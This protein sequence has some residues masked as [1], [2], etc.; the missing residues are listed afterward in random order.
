MKLE[1]SIE[2]HAAFIGKFYPISFAEQD[3]AKGVVGNHSRLHVYRAAAYVPIILAYYTFCGDQRAL[4][5]LKAPRSLKLL[6]IGLLFHDVARRGE[7]KDLWEWETESASRYYKYLRELGVNHT[8]AKKYAEAV[9]NKDYKSKKQQ[10]EEQNYYSCLEVSTEENVTWSKTADEVEKSIEAST[11]HECDCLDIK[12]VRRHFDL[13]FLDIIYHERLEGKENFNKRKKLRAIIANIKQLIKMH[14]DD[15]G[16]KDNDVKISYELATNCYQRIIENILSIRLLRV[17]YQFGMLDH[18]MGTLELDFICQ[19]NEYN[20]LLYRFEIGIRGISK[21][22][23]SGKKGELDAKKE[24]R[25][26]KRK[27]G[28]PLASGSVL[29]LGSDLYANNGYFFRLRI[30]KLREVHFENKRTGF[31]KKSRYKVQKLSPEEKKQK[32]NELWK[33][34]VLGI[35]GHNEILVDLHAEDVLGVFV[36]TGYNYCDSLGKQKFKKKG[37]PY[38]EA[39]AFLLGVI[40]QLVWYKTTGKILSIYIYTET[41]LQKYTDQLCDDEVV[42]NFYCVASKSFFEK[43][44]SGKLPISRLFLPDLATTKK[45]ITFGKS[46]AKIK[47]LDCLCEEKTIAKIDAIIKNDLSKCKEGL[48]LT[49][50]ERIKKISDCFLDENFPFVFDDPGFFKLDINK[51]TSYFSNVGKESLQDSLNSSYKE[52]CCLPKNIRLDVSSE[53]YDVNIED[54]RKAGKHTRMIGKICLL[55]KKLGEKSVLEF[56]QE[57][58]SKKLD[59]SEQTLLTSNELEAIVLLSNVIACW[60]ILQ[61]KWENHFVKMHNALLLK[62]VSIKSRHSIFADEVLNTKN[63]SLYQSMIAKLK[64]VGIERVITSEKLDHFFE[65]LK[66]C[67]EMQSKDLYRILE[68]LLDLKIDKNKILQPFCELFLKH[69][70]GKS[71]SCD[72]YYTPLFFYYPGNYGRK[73]NLPTV[74]LNKLL[75]IFEKASSTERCFVFEAIT[76]YIKASSRR[77]KSLWYHG[78]EDDVRCFYGLKTFLVEMSTLIDQLQETGVEYKNDYKSLIVKHTVPL[79]SRLSDDSDFSLDYSVEEVEVDEVN[80]LHETIKILH[81]HGFPIHPGI[82]LFYMSVV[83]DIIGSKLLPHREHSLLRWCRLDLCFQKK[84]EKTKKLITSRNVLEEEGYG[85]IYKYEYFERYRF[86]VAL[87]DH[88]INTREELD[89]VIAKTEANLGRSHRLKL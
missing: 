73:G 61:P 37:L 80:D 63:L 88:K 39:T 43:I 53:N 54:L 14:G 70:E 12:R 62:I 74:P 84:D 20:K 29:W 81:G 16:C 56:V 6:Q 1:D 55:A 18:D 3:V 66:K 69:F 59:S 44:S 11:V 27:I 86:C 48:K 65:A 32:L 52:E 38:H 75:R 15:K 5:I 31:G 21:P 30:D 26:I 89:N 41:G 2:K 50:K 67:T 57:G 22:S 76:A 8:E 13:T 64:G 25:K 4:A 77:N 49:V 85:M 33:I 47:N 71:F 60:E 68:I 82:M 72:G 34:S 35:Q 7:G 23:K 42:V 19:N 87:C 51:F 46:P 78:D 36:S 45:Y 9:A 40:D 83:K 10:G 58:L 79:F 24:A 17:L 28:N